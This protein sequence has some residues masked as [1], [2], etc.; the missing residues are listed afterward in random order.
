MP[1]DPE[2]LTGKLLVVDDTDL[3]RDML[4]RRLTKRGYDVDVAEGGQQ[5]L[6][7]IAT[8][9]YDVILLDVIMP[10]MDG[11]ETLTHI[12]ERHS[13]TDLPVIMATAKDQSE[14]IVQAFKL[15]A[16]DYV[17]KPLDFQVV[18]ARLQTQL[19]LKQS[20]ERIRTLEQDLQR[21][22]AELEAE[23]ERKRSDL[24]AA[25][26]VQRRCLPADVPTFDDIGF[27]WRYEPC[28]EL[29]G[30]A[31]NIS[32]LDEDNIAVYILDVMGHGVPA[33]LLSVMIGHDLSNRPN[34][35]S[36][37]FSRDPESNR[38]VP[39]NPIDVA[40]KLNELYPMAAPN[41]QFF[42]AVYCC[43]N[44]RTKQL[45]YVNSGHL[46]PILVRNGEAG[47]LST[48]A[49]GPPIGVV[50]EITYSD[51]TIQLQ[52]GDRIYLYSDGIIEL[53]HDQ[54]MYGFERLEQVLAE[55]SDRSL[56]ESID[57][58]FESIQAWTT[59]PTNDDMTVI[60]FQ[61]N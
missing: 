50:P 57:A 30:D 35:N 47:L 34:A 25:A 21:R 41:F 6:E 9:A 18:L 44:R 39:A 46:P 29:G 16:S 14:D 52:P 32:Q 59:T 28:D 55:A 5:A 17:T 60:G 11:F 40:I 2:Q 56:S 43:Y 54:E 49:H 26:R 8:I 24:Q 36:L 12:R 37:V 10:G 7:M 15:G 61:V 48:E 3:N 38:S 27:A 22:N 58:I 53:T 20:V 42:T 51:E 23:I 4:S 45:R 31:I 33:A 19:Q 1:R 13:Q